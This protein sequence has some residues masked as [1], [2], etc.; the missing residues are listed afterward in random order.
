MDFAQGAV[1]NV[2]VDEEAAVFLVVG[3]EMLHTRA[4]P[5]T[6]DGIDESRGQFA[7]QIRVLA[8]RF[9]VAATE[10]VSGDAY[11]SALASFSHIQRRPEGPWTSYS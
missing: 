10:R 4:N 11:C 7:R 2:L 3:R 1:G 8:I 9:E 6:L 5:R